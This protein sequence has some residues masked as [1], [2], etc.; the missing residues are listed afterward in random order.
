MTGFCSWSGGK[1]SCLSLHKALELGFDVKYLVNM[2]N[3]ERKIGHGTP[4]EYVE[5]QASSLGLELVQREVTW[6]SYEDEY[7]NVLSE[8][9]VEYGVF[10]DMELAEH[11]DWVVSFCRKHD[12]EPVLPLWQ[13]DPVDLYRYFVERFKAI[14]VKVDPDYVGGDW[15][16]RRLSIRFL[17]YLLENDVHPMGENGEYHTFVVDGP[18]FQREIDVRVRGEDVDGSSGKI[19]L[20]LS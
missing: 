14:I 2:V 12:V 20:N 5:R 19:S 15:L 1:D 17:D 11:R 6:E 4:P 10:G 9:P 7:D 3:K 16:G 8:L 13:K 18:N